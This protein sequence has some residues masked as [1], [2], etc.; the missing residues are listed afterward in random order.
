MMQ[1]SGINIKF[2]NIQ[3]NGRFMKFSALHI[4]VI[5]ISGPQQHLRDINNQ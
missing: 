5:S 4:N 2:I 3:V 1:L